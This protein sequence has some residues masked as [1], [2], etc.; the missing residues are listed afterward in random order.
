M[1]Q[2]HYFAR[3]TFFYLL[4]LVLSGCASYK[5]PTENFYVPPRNQLTPEESMVYDIY[6]EQAA[7]H[8]LY[9][10]IPR[11]RSQIRWYDLPRWVTWALFGN[12]D[13][14][15]FSEWHVPLFQPEQPVGFGKALAWVLRNPFHN[16][17]F[18]VIGNVGYPND[19]LTLLKINRR[20]FCFFHYEPVAKTVF[21]GRYTSFYLGLHGFKPLISL[22]LA[23]GLRWKS[24]FYIGWREKGNFGIKFLP[25]TK[26]SLAE[27]DNLKYEDSP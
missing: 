10:A 3:K 13:D 27:W 5:I 16:F 17:C 25:L 18:Y 14:G 1:C 2:I 22:R 6:Q 23:Y 20:K 24:D 9:R 15:L 26:V 12:D 4:L 8:W 7:H 19:E 11:H 21:G